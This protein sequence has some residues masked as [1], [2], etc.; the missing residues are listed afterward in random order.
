ML[1]RVAL[2][3]SALLLLTACGEES[4]STVTCTEDCARIPDPVCDGSVQ[5]S[6]LGGGQCV[7]GTCQWV[8]IRTECP[9]GCEAGACSPPPVDPCDGVT[10][11]APPEPRCNATVA[12]VADA[13]GACTD[14]TCVYATTDTDCAAAGQVCDAGFCRAPLPCDGV[15]CDAPPAAF[16]DGRTAVAYPT[17]GICDGGTCSYQEVRTA[18]A[19]AN[20]CIDGACVAVDRCSGVSCTLR[21]RAPPSGWA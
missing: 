5:V 17:A 14:G 21:R 10:C 9:N 19:G 12:V 2:L 6:A 7:E 3:F 18:C 1:K 13:A 15:T 16:C 8:P 4:G 20:D 11:N